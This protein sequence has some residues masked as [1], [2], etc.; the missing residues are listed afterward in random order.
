MDSLCL[1]IFDNFCE[2]IVRDVSKTI[3][4]YLSNDV[5]DQLVIEVLPKFEELSRIFDGDGVANVLV[6]HLEGSLQF[7]VAHPAHFLHRFMV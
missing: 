5:R 3:G 4:I 6:Q 2:F 1:L 7:L